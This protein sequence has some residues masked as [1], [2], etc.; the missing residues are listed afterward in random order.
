MK[1]HEENTQTTITRVVTTKITIKMDITVRR[2]GTK[3]PRIPIKREM[4]RKNPRTR[5][6]T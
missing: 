2:I 3:T 6:S 1:W 4:T 5:M